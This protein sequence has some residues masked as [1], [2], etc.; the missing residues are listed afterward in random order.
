[1]AHD[2]DLFP[3]G[4]Q[5]I[6]GTEALHKVV[7]SFVSLAIEASAAAAGSL[8]VIDET[9]QALIP[10]LT[11]GLPRIYIEG[12]GTIPL[13]EQCCGRAALSKKQWIVADMLTDTLF[14]GGRTAAERSRVRAA[15]STPLIDRDGQCIGSLACHFFEPHTPSS[16]DLMSI[17]LWAEMIAQTL[18]QGR[19]SA[20]LANA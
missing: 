6:G 7:G 9:K 2:F 3:P 14:Q 17:R 18:K 8:Y 11:I 12:C 10:Y 1:M 15:F 13:G 19:S 16:A 20:I 4:L 5:V